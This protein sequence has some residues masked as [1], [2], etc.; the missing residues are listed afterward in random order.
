[1]NTINN[2]PTPPLLRGVFIEV[3]YLSYQARGRWKN[4]YYSDDDDV[5]APAK[6]AASSALRPSQFAAAPTGRPG[7][8][9]A[10]DPA[11]VQRIRQLAQEAEVCAGT[12]EVLVII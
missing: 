9:A 1:M 10:K 4:D 5:I 7:S 12:T 8:K 2:A 11:A 3:V 6:P